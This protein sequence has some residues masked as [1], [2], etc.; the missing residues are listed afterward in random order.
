MNIYFC[1]G[2]IVLSFGIGFIMGGSIGWKAGYDF[3]DRNKDVINSENNKFLACNICVYNDETCLMC[4]SCK[5]RYHE[6]PSNFL[7]RKLP[8][9][10]NN[11]DN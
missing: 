8:K 9:G 5:A 6:Y 1:L 2:F 7:A 3:Y 4:D 10:E 11:N